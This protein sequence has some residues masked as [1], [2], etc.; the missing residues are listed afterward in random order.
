MDNTRVF[1]NGVRRQP[2]G[3]R[4]VE[5]DSVMRRREFLAATASVVAIQAQE[6]NAVVIDPNP[7]LRDLAAPLHAVHGASGDD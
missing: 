7:P 2:S 5:Y 4:K 3:P 6:A 1:S